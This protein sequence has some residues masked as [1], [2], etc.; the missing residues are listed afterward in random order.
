M[1][2]NMAIRFGII[3]IATLNPSFAPSMNASNTFTRLMIPA[4]IKEIIML[5]KIR[6]LKTLEMVPNSSPGRDFR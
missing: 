4:T 1:P 5:N 3:F 6:L 2:T